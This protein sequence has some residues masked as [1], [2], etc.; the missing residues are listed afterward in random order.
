MPSPSGGNRE[1]L[2]LPPGFPAT[3]R[4][5]AYDAAPEGMPPGYLAR[6]VRWLADR[7]YDAEDIARF[8][9][10][11]DE[12]EPAEDEA[13]KKLNNM[14]AR[15][16]N[17]DLEWR[18]GGPVMRDKRTRARGDRFPE[19]ALS[20]SDE[21]YAM[22]EILENVRAIKHGPVGYRHGARVR[23]RPRH[24]DAHLRPRRPAARSGREHQQG[25]REPLQS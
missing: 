7:G 4:G 15:A 10:H 9:E 11:M 1:N 25:G 19:S 14:M 23:L 20:R 6:C 16:A 22:D 17:G 8:C 2:F 12:A 5:A 18:N 24:V 21:R 3:S 13:Q